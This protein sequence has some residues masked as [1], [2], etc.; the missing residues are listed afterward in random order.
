MGTYRI[1]Q[2]TLD[3]ALNGKENTKKGIYVYV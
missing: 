2:R 3:N 1:A